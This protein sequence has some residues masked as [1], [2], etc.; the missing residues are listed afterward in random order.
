MRLVLCVFKIPPQNELG[1]KTEIRNSRS[2][3]FPR[4]KN[5]S[6]IGDKAR[7]KDPRSKN[8]LILST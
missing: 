1:R 4:R 2:R 6:S 3:G 8:D 7:E 5:N